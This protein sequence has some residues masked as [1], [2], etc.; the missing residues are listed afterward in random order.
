MSLLSQFTRFTVL[1][2]VLFSCLILIQFI[3]AGVKSRDSIQNVNDRVERIKELAKR[4]LSLERKSKEKE[5]NQNDN[6]EELIIENDVNNRFN[7]P[8]ESYESSVST[9]SPYTIATKESY[10]MNVPFIS[11]NVFDMNIYNSN[12]SESYIVR[13]WGENENLAFFGDGTDS[14]KYGITTA[15]MNSIGSSMRFSMI[16]L[17]NQEAIAITEDGKIYKSGDSTS[18]LAQQNFE[19]LS[20]WDPERSDYSIVS[21]ESGSSHT[22]IL[23][24]NGFILGRGSNSFSQLGGVVLKEKINTLI[25]VGASWWGLKSGLNDEILSPTNPPRFTHVSASNLYTLISDGL[26]IWTLGY[27]V[28]QSFIFPHDWNYN[29]TL[30]GEIR[31]MST[32]S[33]FFILVN[34]NGEVFHTGVKVGVGGRNLSPTK[35]DFTSEVSIVQCGENHCLALSIDGKT[36]WAFGEINDDG[37]LGD[38]SNTKSSFVPVVVNNPSGEEIAS[39]CASSEFSSFTTVSGQIYVWDSAFDSIDMH[40]LLPKL[41]NT[42][43]GSLLFVDKES[44]PPYYYFYGITNSTNHLVAMGSVDGGQ[45]GTGRMKEKK[46][47]FSTVV[48]RFI[49]TSVRMV[50]IV[51]HGSQKTACIRILGISHNHQLFTWGCNDLAPRQLDLTSY[52]IINLQGEQRSKIYKIYESSEKSFVTTIDKKIFILDENLAPTELLP[53]IKNMPRI[54]SILNTK[55]YIWVATESELYILHNNNY[56]LVENTTIPNSNVIGLGTC[57]HNNDDA[58]IYTLSNDNKIYEWDEGRTT[59]TLIDSSAIP[60]DDTLFQITFGTSHL[61]VLGSK[62]IPYSMGSNS[63][64]QLGASKEIATRDNFDKVNISLV[65]ESDGQII[66]VY[67]F[68]SESYALTEKGFI[69]V[70]GSGASTLASLV[71]EDLFVA[72]SI[73]AL[74]S[75]KIGK[76][77]LVGG[78]DSRLQTAVF[79][80]EPFNCGGYLSGDYRVCS[81][82]GV[83]L[84]QDK[85]DCELEFGGPNCEQF[86]CFNF[87]EKDPNVCSGHGKCIGKDICECD[88]NFTGLDCRTDAKIILEILIVIMI[89]ISSLIILLFLI[90]ILMVC[91]GSFLI[92]R[93]MKRKLKMTSQ[94]LHLLQNKFEMEEMLD[95]DANK[96]RMKLSSDMFEIKFSDIKLL[97][98]IAVGGSGAVVWKSTWKGEYV[99]LKIFKTS[100]LTGSTFFSEFEHEVRLLGSLQNPNIVRFFGACLDHPRIGLVMEWCE[101]GSLVD[102]I[103]NGKMSEMS[104]RDK[105][106]LV[107]QIA[108]GIL[109]LHSKNIIHR[110]LKCDNVLIDEY[111]IAKIA[112]FGLSKVGGSDE[113]SRLTSHVGTSY[114]ISPEVLRGKYD[115]KCDVYSFGIIVYEIF[116]DELEPFKDLFG[117]MR[118]GIENMIAQNPHVRPSLNKMKVPAEG[119]FLFVLVERCWQHNPELRPY[120]EEIV[121]MIDDAIIP[122]KSQPDLLF[123]PST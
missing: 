15:F 103:R 114:Y 80:Y 108:H 12:E 121:T 42:P 29:A 64:G 52:G 72:T 21:I 63:F 99:A 123:N 40:S 86:Y 113:E 84:N 16:S 35:M 32:S 55:N 119:N 17:S 71:E 89:V 120:M 65:K 112:D 26:S 78:L 24:E 107:S 47:D 118:I 5:F 91:L 3:E 25:N 10:R 60:S 101:Q 87:L 81:K 79:A 4:D 70:W 57:F 23:L 83:C 110:D 104:F 106:K 59:S 9:V 30:Y 90:G 61:V 100:Y 39:I 95:A 44:I 66:Q 6:D 14:P 117:G 115:A 74:R 76:L 85:C 41:Y 18:F 68:G 8:S 97:K 43:S 19:F 49:D 13:V 92:V 116:T 22:V 62:G 46:T 96:A 37:S 54:L 2:T 36:L 50:N 34:E 88:A 102:L 93:R 105:L 77:S 20:S 28:D 1:L 53:Q 73:E 33:K 58:N 38:S 98:R 31:D 7:V 69:Y 109:F 51:Q 48:A 82:R 56:T 11:N 45:L 75:Q 94:T 67:S 27:F 111:G 122:K